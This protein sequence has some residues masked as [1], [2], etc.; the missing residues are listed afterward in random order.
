MERIRVICAY[1]GN[2]NRAY[3]DNVCLS[4]EIA[5]TMT[6]DDDG[7]LVSVSSTGLT[8]DVNTYEGGNLI[9]KVTG[10]YGAY[11]YRHTYEENPHRITSEHRRR[12]CV[13]TNCSALRQR[14][15]S[16]VSKNE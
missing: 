4:R 12:F 2:A 1:E 10:G 11:T 16:V 13:L 5:Q 8:P 9:Q 7:N 6:Y 15:G 3:F 14:D